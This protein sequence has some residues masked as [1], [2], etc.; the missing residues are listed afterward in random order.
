MRSDIETSAS[1]DE[2]QCKERG[3]APFRLACR[4]AAGLRPPPSPSGGFS[5]HQ[6][7]NLAYSLGATEIYLLGYDCKG[8][9]ERRH[10]FGNHPEGLSNPTGPRLME[11]AAALAALAHDAE[12]LGVKIVNCSRD[13]ALT[14]FPR[15]TIDDVRVQAA[16]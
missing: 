14:C 12:Q 11:W 13:T 2:L 5:G 4:A 15:M 8:T 9:E 6:A 7:I 10:F 3:L 16:A 1:D